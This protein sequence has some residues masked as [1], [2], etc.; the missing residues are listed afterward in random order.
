MWR[1]FYK[2]KPIFYL[3]QIHVATG[4]KAPTKPDALEDHVEEPAELDGFLAVMQD[5]FQSASAV[6]LGDLKAFKPE[7]RESLLKLI[8]HFDEVAMP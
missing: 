7:P 5:T 1:A 6:Y 8:D 2:R 4:G 3:R